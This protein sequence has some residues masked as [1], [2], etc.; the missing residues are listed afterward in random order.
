MSGVYQGNT[1]DLIPA[2][3]AFSPIGGPAPV[4]GIGYDDRQIPTRAVSINDPG[5][6]KPPNDY[7]IFTIVSAVFCF[8]PTGL[9]AI[10]KAAEVTRLWSIGNSYGALLASKQA[11]LWSKITYTL[12]VTLWVIGLVL[13]MVFLFVINKH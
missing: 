12:G 8:F 1:G 2:P 5:L 4:Y 11:L 6:G 10:M 7:M 3:D 13:I 9:I